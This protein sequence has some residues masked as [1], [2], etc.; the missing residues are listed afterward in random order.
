M[1]TKKMILNAILLAIGAL[2][3]QITPSFGGMQPDFALAMLFI[4]IIMNKDYK[5]TLIAAVITGVFTALTTKTPGGQLP[6]VIDKLITANII[7]FILIPLRNKL[8][9]N[10]KMGIV[11]LLGTIIS[12]TVFLEALAILAGLPAPFKVLFIGIVLPAALINLIAGLV[13]YKS[14]TL[15][16]KRSNIK[17]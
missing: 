9:N 13:L 2:L 12:G 7:Y 1:N 16:L 6:N 5:T 3:H 14:V 10:L 15:A 17:A 8:N 11:L 4:I